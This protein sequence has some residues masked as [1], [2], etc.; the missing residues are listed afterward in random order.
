MLEKINNLEKE[1]NKL[2][3]YKIQNTTTTIKASSKNSASTKRAS[4]NESSR[5][6]MFSIITQD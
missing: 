4:L 3:R 1:N 2:K 6:L 5:Q